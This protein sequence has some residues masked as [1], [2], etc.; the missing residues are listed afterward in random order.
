MK[1]S[2]NIISYYILEI[3]QDKFKYISDFNQGK[4]SNGND[5]EVKIMIKNKFI[6]DLSIYKFDVFEES[7]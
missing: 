3:T 6:N 4:N 5:R 7:D 2:V 1:H